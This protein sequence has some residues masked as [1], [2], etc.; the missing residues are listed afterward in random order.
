MMSLEAASAI[1][2]AAARRDSP[3]E[4]SMTDSE[5]LTHLYSTVRPDQLCDYGD[6]ETE[7][8]QVFLAH[9]QNPSRRDLVDLVK[10]LASEGVVRLTTIQDVWVARAQSGEFDEGR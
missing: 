5:L 10:L 8:W 2:L 3:D 9:H 1:V 6:E 4:S 7:A